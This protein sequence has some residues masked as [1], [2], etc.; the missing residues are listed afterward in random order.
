M[1]SPQVEKPKQTTE[2][3]RLSKEI[4]DK[5]DGLLTNDGKKV[6]VFKNAG[7]SKIAKYGFDLS[8]QTIGGEKALPERTFA[9]EVTCQVT[10]NRTPADGEA[11]RTIVLIRVFDEGSQEL[12]FTLAFLKG[13]PAS[14]QYH[15]EPGETGHNRF[16]VREATREDLEDFLDILEKPLYTIDR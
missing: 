1:E 5:A 8:N 10:L 4:L 15:M 2:Q 12:S 11:Q 14:F 9:S 13:R 6:V 3:L 7:P 16:Y